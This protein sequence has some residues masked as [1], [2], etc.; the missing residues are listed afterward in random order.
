MWQ[1]KFSLWEDYSLDDN[2]TLYETSS[3]IY[4]YSILVKLVKFVKLIEISK[5]L[6]KIA[7]NWEM[8]VINVITRSFNAVP[9][10][11]TRVISLGEVREEGS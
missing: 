2:D 9:V 3:N 10:A 6:K 8:A 11:I 1:I 4:P 5:F 7:V